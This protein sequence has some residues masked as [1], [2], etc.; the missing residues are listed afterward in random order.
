[1]PE[2]VLLGYVFGGAAVLSLL[3]A[4]LRRAE[5]GALLL[6]TASFAGASVFA[7][8]DGF[9]AIVLCA[10][11]GIWSLVTVP[12]WVDFG[13]RMRA[14]LVLNSA[15]LG[16]LVMWPSLQVMSRGQIACPPYV[17]KHVGYQLVAGLDLKGGLRLVYS[18]EVD[19]AIADKRNHFLEELRVSLAKSYGLH[20]GSDAPTEK[21][22]TDLRQ[23]VKVDA[24]RKPSN[25]ITLEF[26]SADEAQRRIDARLREQFRTDLEFS[27]AGPLVTAKLLTS[28][29]SAIRDTAVQQAKKT[30]LRRIDE[31][32][33]REASVSTRDEDIIIEAPGNDEKQFDEIRTLVAKT[34]RLEFKLADDGNDYMRTL[35]AQTTSLPPQVTFQTTDAPNGVATDG[36]TRQ[37]TT[38]AIAIYTLAEKEDGKAGL[39]TFRKWIESLTLPPDR[40]LGVEEWRD[41]SGALK[42][43]TAFLLR[44][45]ADVTGDMIKDA[46]ARPDGQPGSDGWVVSFVLN[47]RG[48]RIFDQL[49]AANINRRFAIILD[50]MVQSAPVIRSRISG[51]GQIDMGRG[52]VQEQLKS[53]KELEVVLR[54]GALPAP[55]VPSN[56]QRIGS[57]LGE[58]AILLA[59]QG[60]LGGGLLVLFFM[61]I[62]Y[63]QGGIVANLAVMLN[64]FLQLAVLATLGAAITL[65]GIAGLALTIG[66]SVDGNVLI[67]ERIR[68]EL[69][70]GKSLRAA[71]DLGFNRA[72]SA[73]VDGHMTTLIS[74]VVLAQ[75]GTGPVR[76]FAVTLFVGTIASI[77]TSVV[78]SRTLVDAWVRG[79]HRTFPFGVG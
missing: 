13:W 41:G 32:G 54:S 26:A 67:N 43:Y 63:R 69:R 71:V 72:L 5:R 60:A 50:G 2:S 11:I 52:T 48:S 22:L 3:G 16:F 75:Y 62:Y 64:L 39:S 44:S 77:F 59:I 34:A 37:K 58:D 17:M 4:W 7:F 8:Y 24:P 68:D 66:M 53:A 76:G 6:A 49:T 57:T 61:G 20:Q 28:T 27:F 31:L 46:Q 51:S 29:E 78:V 74:A 15:L 79:F 47:E 33:V 25:R 70:E 55:I 65:P 35:S 9:W 23:K 36:K 21:A 1:M 73:I 45:R 14:G 19:E 38:T 12:D 18:V 40:E 10:L 42:G 30:V 56:E